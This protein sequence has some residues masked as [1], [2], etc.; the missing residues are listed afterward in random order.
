MPFYA[1]RCDVHDEFDVQLTYAEVDERGGVPQSM[2]CP[3]LL[4]EGDED[5]AGEIRP[6]TVV[7]CNEDSPLVLYPGHKMMFDRKTRRKHSYPAEHGLDSDPRLSTKDP[8]FKD[9]IDEK[10]RDAK[11]KRKG[12]RIYTGDLGKPALPLQVL[13]PPKRSK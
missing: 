4:Y 6:D 2:P 10:A 5:D 7:L 13:T 11:N 3:A 8:H 9:K 12:R 1:F